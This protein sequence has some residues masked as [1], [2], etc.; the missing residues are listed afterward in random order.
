MQMKTGNEHTL[1]IAMP[2]ALSKA[3]KEIHDLALRKISFVTFVYFHATQ[4]F[5]RIW[6][7]AI[8]LQDF[9]YKDLGCDI[10]QHIL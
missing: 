9:T 7:R 1:S 2:L 10:F 8:L 4:S 6:R 5:R 3:V